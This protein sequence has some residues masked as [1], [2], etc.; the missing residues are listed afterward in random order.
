MAFLGTADLQGLLPSCITGYDPK[1]IKEVAYEL[2][3]GDEAYLTDS[4]SGKK[5]ILDNKNTQV[6]IKPGQFALLLTEE[7]VTIPK[8]LHLF[9]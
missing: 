3:L 6:V 5:E 9:L 7:I 8:G 1:R 4:S 2:A